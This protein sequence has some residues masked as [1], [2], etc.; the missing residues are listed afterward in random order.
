[1]KLA[2]K[3]LLAVAAAI[4]ANTIRL[5]VIVNLRSRRLRRANPTLKVIPVIIGVRSPLHLLGLLPSWFPS[6]VKPNWSFRSKYDEAANT[7][8]DRFALCMPDSTML[9][10][11]DGRVCRDIMMNRSREIM[12]PFESY[13]V[14]DVYGE[15]D[16]TSYGKNLVTTEGEVWRRHKK[17][18]APAFSERNNARVHEVVCRI[19]DSMFASWEQ[20]NQSG[21]EE[22]IINVGPDMM[23]LALSV[24]SSAG[25]GVDIPWH[26]EDQNSSTFHSGKH[27]LSFKQ[28]LEVITTNGFLWSLL[29]KFL[30]SLPIKF[31]RSIKTGAEEFG[32]YLDEIADLAE[33]NIQEHPTNLIELLVKAGSEDNNT[34][35]KLSRNELKG[36][37][38]IFLFAGHE[39][40]ANTLTFALAL[41]ALNPEKQKKLFD[42]I[43]RELNGNKPTYSDLSKLKYALAIM[44]ETL[45]MFPPV[46]NIP[47]ITTGS[48]WTDIDGTV[49][50][51]KTNVRISAV[52]MHYN[53]NIWGPTVNEFKPER[54]LEDGDLEFSTTKLGFAAFSE[55][56][57]A[58]VG[59]KF[60]QIE[61]VTLLTLVSQ[62]YTWR[63]ADEK[64]T[65]E[66]VLDAKVILVLNPANPVRL[67]F[68]AR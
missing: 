16:A 22:R 63:V 8:G 26:T 67:A 45:R 52:G 62:K 6:R 33:S 10:L 18:V 35:A 27:T 1:M 17:I 5:T 12:K 15:L 58:C 19:A 59:K 30:F 31:L 40:T 42:E 32:E 53:P 9:V 11:C 23:E 4:C 51:P 48:E 28:A 41:L 66:Y 20:S 68:T 57:R 44:N 49:V 54:F 21:T 43:Q 14:L 34:S 13:T 64:L 56:P 60:A 3:V 46:N 7:V 37:M 38:F 24:I 50:P 2:S 39:T 61:F 65:K 55:G 29:P 36:N 25:F 47:K